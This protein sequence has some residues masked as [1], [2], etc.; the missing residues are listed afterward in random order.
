MSR[1]NKI[2][3]VSIP[4]LLGW[5]NSYLSGLVLLV[6][7]GI[8]IK[9]IVDLIKRKTTRFAPALLFTF[10]WVS[11]GTVHDLTIESHASAR[12]RDGHLSYSGNRSGTCSWHGGV[13][14]WEPRIP[15]WWENLPF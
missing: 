6:F 4:V 7:L 12:C 13:A 3:L 11:V 10:L 8:A 2:A 15:A 14:E 5:F 1:K 9:I